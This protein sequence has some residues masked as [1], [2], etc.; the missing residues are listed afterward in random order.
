MQFT[1]NV[2]CIT[3]PNFVLISFRLSDPYW[4]QSHTQTGYRTSTLIFLARF[5]ARLSLVTVPSLA[6]FTG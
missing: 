3:S 1:S 2:T 5:R 4:L 6:A